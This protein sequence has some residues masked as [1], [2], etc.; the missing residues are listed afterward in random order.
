MTTRRKILAV[1]KSDWLRSVHWSPDGQRLAYIRYQRSSGTFQISI[2]TCDLKRTSRTVVLPADPLLNDFCWM[3]KGRIVYLRQD[4]PD[5]SDGNVWLI[6]VDKN[7]GTPAGNPKRMTQWAGSALLATSTSADGKRLLLLKQTYQD[8][9][10]LGELAAGGTRMKPPRRLTNDEGSDSPTA[11]T[12]DSKT[13]LFLSDRNRTLGIYKQ[14]IRQETAEPIFT[15]PQDV[16]VPSRPSADGA[17]VLSIATRLSPDG[18]WILFAQAQ[19]ASADPTPASRIMRFPASGGV[20]Q[21]VLDSRNFLLAFACARAP[22]SL[23]VFLEPSLDR[24]Q[25][26]ITAFDPLKGR[27]RVLRTVDDPSYADHTGLSPDGKTFA[28]SRSG[29]AEIHIRLFSLSGGSD[30]EITVKGWQNIT[31]LD[32]SADGKGFYCGSQSPQG[33]TLLYIDLKGN[34]LALWQHK[35]GGGQIWGT[36]SPDGRYLAIQTPV[37]SSNIWMVEGF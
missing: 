29:E 15:R 27:G 2:E 32:W 25:F 33:N 37:T 9:A 17:W 18:A 13:V 16:D 10:Y 8:Q 21:L 19:K 11:W 6:G 31:G 23:C 3:P 22:A 12:A 14:G 5:S 35:G 1:E 20:P 4:S 30:R 24:K 7:S 34:A 28:I 36:P 26:M